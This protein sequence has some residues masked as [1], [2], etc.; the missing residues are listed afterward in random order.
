MNQ[1]L[2]MGDGRWN[3]EDVEDPTQQGDCADGQSSEVLR[4]YR[5]TENPARLL[6][7]VLTRESIP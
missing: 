6:R 1:I 5:D 4:L 2:G 3:V 7:I